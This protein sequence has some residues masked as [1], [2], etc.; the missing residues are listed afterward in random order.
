M[1]N[2]PPGAKVGRPAFVGRRASAPAR[3]EP[4]MARQ[5]APCLRLPGHKH[6]WPPRAGRPP[7]GRPRFTRPRLS[8]RTRR[9]GTEAFGHWMPRPVPKRMS[10]DETLRHEMRAHSRSLA[11]VSVTIKERISPRAVRYTLTFTLQNRGDRFKLAWRN[12]SRAPCN[13]FATGIP[14]PCR[15]FPPPRQVY[16]ILNIRQARPVLDRCPAQ[17]QE[18]PYNVPATRHRGDM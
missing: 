18:C 17:N 15:S 9:Y 12:G 2:P 10:T 7:S 6:R 3:A 16:A 5:A 13:R 8:Q 11:A 14:C 1:D 4:R